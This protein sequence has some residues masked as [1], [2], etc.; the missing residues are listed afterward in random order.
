VIGA[1][2]AAA[3]TFTRGTFTDATTGIILASAAPAIQLS[4]TDTNVDTRISITS[5]GSLRLR[6]DSNNE[7][8]GSGILFEVDNT[9]WMTLDANGHLR[10]GD[11]TDPT[12]TAEFAGTDAVL[13]PVGTEAQRPTGVKGYLRFNDDTDALE[14]HDGAAWKSAAGAMTFLATADASNDATIDFTFTPADYD[15]I[16]LICRGLVPATDAASLLVRVST[17]GGS[18]YQV[19]DYNS[20]VIV[21]ATPATATEGVNV[22]GAVGSGTNEAGW[23]GT[24]TLHHPAVVARPMIHAAGAVIFTDGNIYPTNAAGIYTVAQD[25][26]ALRLLFT[27]GNIESGS[28]TAYGMRSS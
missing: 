9:E 11:A 23:S 21:R 19:N 13:L 18:T 7:Q 26:D 10:V 24:I 8:A 3:A 14:I 25:T 17:D 20:E 12:V 2:S 15:A 27:S 4:D 28:V 6:A 5:D 22:S 16:V 1:N